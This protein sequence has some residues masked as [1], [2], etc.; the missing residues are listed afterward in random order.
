MDTRREFFKVLLKLITGTGVFLCYLAL[1]IRWAY[2]NAER[3]IPPQ[4]TKRETLIDKD[5]ESLDT[6]NLEITPLRDF[7]TMGLADFEV[8]M[9]E[10][11][12]GVAGKVK[13]PLQLTYTEIL[14]LPSV[15]KNVLLICPGFFANYGRW[16]GVSMKD[17]LSR[18]VMERGVTHIIFYSGPEDTYKREFPLADV[19]ANRVF[20]AYRVNGEAL[21]IRDGY[22]LRVVAEGYCGSD[23]I[24]YVSK[25]S[26]GRA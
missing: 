14:S 15:E 6:R 18:A 19:L 23:W 26:V 8:D 4:G 13:A 9:K 3:V 17:L 21:P 1:P 22:P 7:E 5:P 25:M 11:R 16:Q 2:S 20:L 12:L 24:K 10:W